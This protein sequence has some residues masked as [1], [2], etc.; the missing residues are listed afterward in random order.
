M[1]V[2]CYATVQFCTECAKNRV[3]PR[4]NTKNM[5]LFPARALLDFVAID[6][7]GRI[8]STRR[9]NKFLL[10]INNRFSKLVRTVPLKRI[11]AFTVAKAFV[12]HW[13]FVYG[14]P[15]ELLSDK[16]KQFASRFF[17]DVCCIFDEKTLFTMM[18]HPQCN[19]QVE[20]FDR[21]LLSSLRCYVADHPKIW[22]L[23]MDA[24]TFAYNTQVYQTTGVSP[25]E[26]VLSRT[27]PPVAL[28]SQATLGNFPSVGD[29][30]QKWKQWLA[31]LVPAARK[32]MARAQAACKKD[33]K[34]RLRGGRTPPIAAI[35]HFFVRK[36]YYKL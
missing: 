1:A 10:V 33:F 17:Q 29:Y 32:S 18:Y 14:S 11:T 15:V 16:G 13:T 31:K 22:D 30:R 7:L 20:R 28:E 36:E 12:T 19:G 34:A 35:Q 3:K 21:T 8:F 4:K 23:Y 2:D 26:L 5:K 9:G 24:F 6:I 27:P 25:F